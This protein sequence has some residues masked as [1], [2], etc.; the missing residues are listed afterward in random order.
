MSK[1]P[2]ETR[3]D[4]AIRQKRDQITKLESEIA[5]LGE[6]KTIYEQ[7]EREQERLNRDL[8]KPKNLRQIGVRWRP[9]PT[10]AEPDPKW[11]FSEG[12]LMSTGDVESR[13]VYMEIDR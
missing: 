13:I 3:I 2:F 7:V 9:K 12:P 6:S 10:V 8:P 1:S 11:Q 4:N 5:A